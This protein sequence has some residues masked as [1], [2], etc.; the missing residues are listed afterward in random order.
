MATALATAQ[1]ANALRTVAE[2]SAPCSW[3]RRSA[4]EGPHPGLPA[5]VGRR[6][7]EL[8]RR[9]LIRVSVGVPD[10]DAWGCDLAGELHELTFESEVLRDNPLGDPASRPLLVYTP[11][12]WPDGG[13]YPAVW[14]IQ[15]LLGQVDQW[16]ERPPRRAVLRAP[17]P[18]DRGWDLPAGGRAD[19]GLLDQV[20]RLPV[21]GLRRDRALRD[22]PMRRARAVGRRALRDGTRR[23]LALGAGQVIRRLRRSRAGDAAS[24]CVGR[25]LGRFAGA[26]RRRLPTV[27]GVGMAVRFA[28]G[29]RSARCARVVAAY[30]SACCSM[31]ST[32]SG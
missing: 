11:P 16:R 29:R 17:G 3:A 27:D 9:L 26:G 8:V 23:R 15:G 32:R 2:L 21:L 10:H 14:M 12:G 25:R 22:P 31:R 20:R 18:D 28:V 30:F 4:G 1:Y 19:A 24:G 13:P 7:E 5:R 6:G